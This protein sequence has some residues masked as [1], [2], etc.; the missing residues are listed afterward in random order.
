MLSEPVMQIG[1]VGRFCVASRNC[2]CWEYVCLMQYSKTHAHQFHL[3]DSSDSVVAALQT[4]LT[5]PHLKSITENTGA[6]SQS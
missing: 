4:V 6:V 2:F 3:M 1:C 5:S